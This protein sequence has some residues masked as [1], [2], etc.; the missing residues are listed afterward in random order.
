MPKVSLVIATY[1]RID[2]VP[3]TID[4]ALAQTRPFD[5]IIVD[6]D[7][8]PDGTHDWLK[9]NYPQVLALQTSGNG[10]PVRARNLGAK[11]STRDILVFFD[12]DDVMLPGSLQNFLD[13]F[14]EYPE[15]RAAFTDNE[16]QHVGQGIHYRNH[17]LHAGNVRAI[18]GCS[19]DL[20]YEIDA[21]VRSRHLQGDAET[22][23]RLMTPL[24]PH[25][26]LDDSSPAI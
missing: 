19:H 21:V 6:D 20:P 16:Y 23:V 11:M 25:N 12:D 7:C 9:Q 1:D 10:G 24:K 13:L 14:T 17:H 18:L 15:A 5:E 4:S 22:V 26:A 3:A 2:L 8:S